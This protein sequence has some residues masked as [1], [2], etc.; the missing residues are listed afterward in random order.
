MGG[1]VDHADVGEGCRVAAEKILVVALGRRGA[2][3]VVPVRREP[4]DGELRGDAA[5]RGQ[6]VGDP[7]PA[8][9]P[10]RA[11]RPE[12]LHEGGRVRPG[13]LE[14][15]ERGEIHEAGPVAHRP[16]LGRD[17]LPPRGAP[18]GGRHGA[19]L[20]PCRPGAAP[21]RSDDGRRIARYVP[22]RPGAPEGGRRPIRS[23]PC[24]PEGGRLVPRSILC[25]FVA[26]GEPVRPLP[27]VHTAEH[28]SLRRLDRVDRRRPSWPT[29]RAFLEGVVHPELEAEALH[30][31]GDAVVALR[32]VTAESSR[33]DGQR[34]HRRGAVDHPVGE[35]ASGAAALHHPHARP[36]QHPGVVEPE[37]RPDERV[38][39]RR[40]RD[41]TVHDGL[42][43]GPRERR[44]PFH[45]QR[46]DGLDPVQLRRQQLH[47]ELRRHAVHAPRAAVR[48]VG[49][50]DEPVA[51]LAQ[52][53]ALLRV[54]D[55]RQ[56]RLPGRSALGDLRDP[57]GDQV[58]V[59]HRDH[60]QIR[61][62]HR[63]DLPAPGTRRVDHVPAADRVPVGMHRPR[64]RGGALD[65]PHRRM[66]PDL[67][68]AGSRPRGERVGG[69]RRVDVPVVRLVDRTEQPVDARQRV[70][71]RQRLG[72]E[73]AELVAHEPP[74]P[75][76]VAELVHALRRARDPERAAGVEPGALPGLR[77]QHVP[78]Q[79]HRFRA[80][81]HDRGVVGEVGAEPGRV[82]GRARGELVLL[83]EHDIAPAAPGQMPG[84]RDPHDATAHDHR[85]RIGCHRR[86]PSIL[87][88]I[89]GRPA[90]VDTG[91][92]CNRDDRSRPRSSGNLRTGTPQ[93]MDPVDGPGGWTQWMD[94]VDG[95]AEPSRLPGD[96]TRFPEP[97]D[98]TSAMRKRL[99]D[100]PA[101]RLLRRSG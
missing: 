78:V 92:H 65:R 46:R 101:P 33:I 84:E 4:G 42:D 23:V 93:G 68:P 58:L 86:R 72:G 14:L 97:P 37:G 60:R 13:D 32:R 11:V 54:A 17:R 96:Y 56:L 61:P 76:H 52:V 29:G 95:P 40:E 47:A 25:R 15:G 26:A 79:A 45:G 70:D 16:A 64:A 35:E 77:R 55:D 28:R 2:R 94:V 39:V 100:P 51:L 63:A 80:H 8:H 22:G 12:A 18:E 24:R 31:L 50:E 98:E 44:H 62:H 36:G 43:A 30:R 66:A 88:T 75:L 34:V 53:P 99:L 27:A 67:G 41:R 87:R 90:A 69:Q 3:E 1:A 9:R 83:Q 59:Q 71:P 49:T 38:R 81:R 10:R 5:G 19:R 57:G 6:R 91:L 20:V 7:D 21:G 74:E 82:P 85:L 73:D 48:L 89:P